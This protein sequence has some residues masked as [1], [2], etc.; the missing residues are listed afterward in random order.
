MLRFG[1]RLRTQQWQ[2]EEEEEDCHDGL[3]HFRNSSF[4]IFLSLARRVNRDIVVVGHL[5]GNHSPANL[6]RK[7]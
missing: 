3:V 1:R 2:E 6:S 4:S 5:G 7:T